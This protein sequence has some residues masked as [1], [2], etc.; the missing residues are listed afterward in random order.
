MIEWIEGIEGGSWSFCFFIAEPKDNFGLF[1]TLLRP[2]PANP[3][4]IYLWGNKFRSC[5]PNSVIVTGVNTS[6]SKDIMKQR[7]PITILA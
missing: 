2:K 6:M 3:W 5:I 1:F 4:Y 7:T